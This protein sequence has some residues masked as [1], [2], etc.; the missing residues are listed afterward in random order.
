MFVLQRD[1]Q[2]DWPVTVQAPGE[3]VAVPMRFSARWRLV[4]LA[5]AAALARTE[6]GIDTLLRRAIV[7]LRD[8][9]DEAGQPVPHGPALLEALL[10]IPWV[11]AGLVRAYADAVS[12]TPSA[13]AAGN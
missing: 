3:G 10:A 7:E 13:A 8:I 1:P 11:R 9:V 2:W 5:E 6:E 4:P 12:G